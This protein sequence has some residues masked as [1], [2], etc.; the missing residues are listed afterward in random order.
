MIVVISLAIAVT[1]SRSALVAIGAG[2]AF[3]MLTDRRRIPVLLAAAVATVAIGLVFVQSSSTGVFRI[4]EG[5]RAKEKIASTNVETRLTAWGA[6]VTLAIDHPLLGIGPGN[7]FFHY[8]DV[9]GTP[10]GAEPL[11]VVHNAYLDIGSELGLIG[12]GLFL[13]YLALV[14]QRLT[15]VHRLRT[16][17]PGYAAALRVSLVMACT[18]AITLSEQYSAPFWLIGG[19]ATALWLEARLASGHVGAFELR[20]PVGWSHGG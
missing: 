13:A 6:A 2:I 14:F 8:G 10:P 17:P 4:E 1:Y 18:G 20:R 19:L 9:T 11:G 16:G 7:F 5:L 12:L 15:S 3:L